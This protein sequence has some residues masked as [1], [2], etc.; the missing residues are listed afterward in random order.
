MNL[1]NH[2]YKQPTWLLLPVTAA[3]MAAGATVSAYAATAAGTEIKNLATVSY[4]DAAGNTYT[5][6]SN[7]AV[8]TVAQVYSATVNS[9]DTNLTASPGQPVDISYTLENTGNGPDTYVL[10]AANGIVGGDAIDAD[11]VTIYEDLNNNGQADAGEPVITDLTLT[12]GEIKSIVVRADVPTNAIAGEDLGITLTAEAEEG[13][14]AAVAASV[15]DLT[16]GKGPDT[17]DSTVESLITVT[18]D[19][20]IVSTKS[21]VHNTATNEITYTVTVMN[22]GN[23]DATDV[24]LLDAIPEN[25]TLVAGSA[26]TSG[27]ITSNGDTL[28]ATAVLDETTL[29]IDFNGDGDATD[30]GLDGINAVDAVLPPNATVTISYT[31]SYD[32]AVVAGGTVISNIAYVAADVDGDGVQDAPGSTNQVNDTVNDT[33]LV[34]IT[35]TGEA[36]GGDGI[37]DGQDDDAAN[38]IQLVDQ[39]SAGDVVVFKN[40]V[41]N[42]G[43]TDDVLEL[44]YDIGTFPVGTIITFWNDAGTVQLSDS[45][46]AFGP[47]AG[48]IAA[49]ASETITVKAQLPSG[50]SGA[51]D[52]DALVTVTSAADPTV[53]D[54]V[55]EKLSLINDATIDIHNASGGTLGTDE[56]PIGTPAY[57]PVNTIAADANSTVDIPLFI[58]NDGDAPNSFQLAVGGVYD[59]TT[60]TVSALPAGWT[61]E[62]FLADAAGAPTGAAITSTPV[63]AGNT[64]DFA[65]VAVVTIPADQTQAVGDYSADN[66]GDG[67]VDTIDGNGDGDGDYSL[68]FQISSAGTGA[69]DVTMESI[70]VNPTIS[71]SL[72]PNGSAQINP[73]GTEEYLNTLSNNGN[74]VQT[75]EIASTNSG[76]G[77]TST[78]SVDTDG[79]GVADTEIAN[80]TPGTIQVQQP[81]GSVVTVEVAIGAGGNPEFTLDAGEELPIAATVFAPA[82][83]PDGQVD[84]LTITATNTVTGDVVTAQNQTQAVTGQVNIVKTVAVDTDCDGAA[85]TPFAAVQPASVA[86]EPDQ[87]V[88]WQVVAQNQGAADA[89]NVQIHDAVPAFTTFVPGSLSYCLNQNCTVAPVTDV[90][91]DDAG[92]E[93]AGDVVFYIGGSSTPASGLGGEL[94]SGDFATV[95]FSVRVD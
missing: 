93:A 27:L 1:K 38:D 71:A 30:T 33:L 35:D 7:E 89:F 75:Y 73:G 84:V 37:N 85:D 45:N 46:S 79:D 58:D 13:T 70:D 59:A 53:T 5:A 2:K 72:S 47:D 90:V 4:E 44:S 78:L 18:G 23:A 74:A 22:N 6:Q 41:T 87:C 62:Y 28:P 48:L 34:S 55:T 88:I 52:F 19:A 95:Q 82:T 36:T 39:I 24:T 86:V 11:T 94:V 69:T 57:V 51:G 80:L 91:G 43:N 9:T 67:A 92:E 81:D 49:G 3:L 83:A 15:V 63:I 40:I 61:V 8:V 12:A 26:T 42:S 65:I 66:D 10:S 68:F 17:F 16:A 31:V 54:T 25:T 76:P 50:F 60:D 21:S 77:W 32:P 20:V 56:N 29:S 14:G 64:T